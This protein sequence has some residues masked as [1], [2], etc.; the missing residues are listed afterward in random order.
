MRKTGNI[1]TLFCLGLMI[2]SGCE[3]LVEV[4]YP[5]NQLG[6]IQVFEDVQIANSA[7]AG[8]YADLRDQSIITGGSY[9]GT[10]ALSGSYTD[11]LDCYNTT[12]GLMD[13]YQNQQQP[14]NTFIASIWN[15]AYRQIYYA[16]SIIYGAEQSTELSEG[17]KNR[18]KGE[19]LL[20]RSLIYFY[21][22]QLFDDIP[23]TN[24]LDY[25][26]NRNLGKTEGS[27]LLEQLELDLKEAVSL[28]EDNYRD[29]ERIYPNRK[30]A[31][32]LLAK[33]YLTLQKYTEAELTAD[34]ILQSPLYQFQ[35]DINEVFHKTGS[36]ILWQ[37][38]PENNDDPVEEATFY[39]FT[40]S[41]PN[42]YVLTV[43]LVN[44]FTDNDLRKQAW[45]FEET[46]NEHSW[47][48]PCKYKNRFDNN[49]EYS[50]V[51]RL[52]EVYFILAEALAKQ[53]L[54]DEA[55]PYL[56][57]TRERAGLT[58][59][60]SLSGDNFINELLEEKRREFF[61]E[62]GHRFLD[63]KRMGKLNEL[64]DVKPNWEEFK[65]AWPLPQSELLLNSN[66]NPQNP[67]Y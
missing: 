55:L 47:Y 26:Y 39:Y 51:F 46:F 49:N 5:S 37:L 50:I 36:H 8:L 24:I 61:A 20:I 15:T 7:L 14:T 41:A 22:Q 34:A 40:G 10:N 54:F 38:K 23:Y 11:D 16:N 64:S 30:V 45:M 66:M 58:A 32:L 13:I 25:E 60:T 21:L 18:I 4:D 65:S 27:S 52:E 6:T 62:S 19:A 67:G 31:E 12:Q 56:N 43:G 42:S 28:M 59:F 9:Y 35:P 33:V 1:Y 57:T 2:L 44:T 63:L 17:D 3:D 53:N 29:T 48:R